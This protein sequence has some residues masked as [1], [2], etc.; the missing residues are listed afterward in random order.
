MKLNRREFL[1][2]SVA[3]GAAGVLAPTA[4]AFTPVSYTH[5][6]LPTTYPVSISVVAVSFKKK[7]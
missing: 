6:T 5:L 7:L 2:I 1:G 4:Q 3:T